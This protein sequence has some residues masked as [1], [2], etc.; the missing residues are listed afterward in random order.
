MQE[1]HSCAL[2]HRLRLPACAGSARRARTR[3]FPGCADLALRLPLA[4]PHRCADT[5]RG[6][7]AHA[8]ARPALPSTGKARPGPARGCLA[9]RARDARPPRCV[10]A[11][12]NTL[13]DGANTAV[14]RPRLVHAP[15]GTSHYSAPLAKIPPGT[16]RTLAP[17]QAGPHRLA[18]LLPGLASAS[19][20]TRPNRTRS[21]VRPA[22]AA[23][24][25]WPCAA[26]AEDSLAHPPAR[27][28]SRKG[29]G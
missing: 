17:T 20:E 4:T 13:P 10:P 3:W 6:P 23:S 12:G 9:R 19:A 7:P 25:G 27:A 24:P 29:P 22:P 16:A 26:A 28:G 14:G 1:R 21:H 8:P 5:R 18:A 15:R 2:S 11:A